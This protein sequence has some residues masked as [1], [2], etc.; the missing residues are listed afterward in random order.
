MPGNDLS[1]SLSY[2]SSIMVTL[3]TWMRLPALYRCQTLHIRKHS[4]SYQDVNPSLTIASFAPRRLLPS[5]FPHFVQSLEN[6]HFPS[7]PLEYTTTGREAWS[8]SV[9]FQLIL[10]TME[11]CD[12]NLIPFLVF[13]IFNFNSALLL[14][15]SILFWWIC[16]KLI[17]VVRLWNMSI[18][19]M[20]SCVSIQLH[21]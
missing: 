15:C 8:H 7:P 13:L 9:D 6:G 19:R 10:K 17:L 2:F 14:N 16:L 4:D 1:P 11:K 18:L 5:A 3:L 21:I 20:R 12:R